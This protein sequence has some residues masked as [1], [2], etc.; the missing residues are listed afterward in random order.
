EKAMD[1]AMESMV[2]MGD[3]M[4]ETSQKHFNEEQ[5]QKMQLRMFQMMRSITDD[6]IKTDDPAAA[7][8]TQGTAPLELMMGPPDF[9]NLTEG[10]KKEI[11]DVQKETT[12]AIQLTSQNVIQSNAKNPEGLKKFQEMQELAGKVQ[13]A[14]TDEERQE[15]A[16]KLLTIHSEMF[17][18]AA[19]EFKKILKEGREKYDAVLTDAQ[20]AKIKAVMEQ[21]PEYLW[22]SLPQNQGKNRSWR[23]GLNS[24]IPG[25]GAPE[26]T[27]NI[28]EA[29]PESKEKGRRFPGN[30]GT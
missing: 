4:R 19:P 20:R 11:F 22:Q 2:E 7:T 5:R 16:Q 15:I 10:Q 24:W 23:P 18:D 13:K 9:L 8:I 28:R 3:V 1:I 21:I 27:E 17:K 26:G 30:D 6:A 14:E 29:K 25:M 12:K